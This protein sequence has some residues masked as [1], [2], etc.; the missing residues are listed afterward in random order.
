MK[1]SLCGIIFLTAAFFFGTV[2]AATLEEAKGLSEKAATFWKTNGKDKAIAEFNNAKG[3]FAKGDLYIV[4]HDFKGVVL[5]HGTNASLVGV[6]LYEQKEPNGDKYF[7]KE[8]IEIAKTKGSGWIT[9]SWVNPVT[10]KIQPK[11]SW[12]QR[13]EGVDAFVLCG[14]FQ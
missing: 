2:Y 11:K 10:K 5:A 12:V 1:R 4:A 13:I 14:V 9:Y 8:E 7:V 6:N 3:Q